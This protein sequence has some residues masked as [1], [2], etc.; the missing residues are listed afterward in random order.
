L[1]A[2]ARIVEIG[3]LPMTLSAFTG[4]GLTIKEFTI[5]AVITPIL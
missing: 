4:N 2:L 1:K 5:L 3:H